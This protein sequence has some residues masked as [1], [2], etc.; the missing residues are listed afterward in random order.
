VVEEDDS[1]ISGWAD[2][3]FVLELMIDDLQGGMFS[4]SSSWISWIM[5]EER[6]MFW[7]WIRF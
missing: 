6:M 2:E 4:V 1:S 5:L 3:R 7:D